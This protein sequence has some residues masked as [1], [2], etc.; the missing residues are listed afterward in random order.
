[1]LIWALLWGDFADGIKVMEFRWQVLT[2]QIHVTPKSREV[3]P[4]EGKWKDREMRQ[5][6]KTEI[7]SPSGRKKVICQGIQQTLEAENDLQPMASKDTETSV[8]W[9]QGTKSSQP[10][11]WARKQTVHRTAGKVPASWQLEFSLLKLGVDKLAEPT[12][13]PDQLKCEIINELPSAAKS[14]IIGSC[15]TASW[16]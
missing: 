4:A 9:L 5:K 2:E 1:M 7:R 6:G 8:L 13:T 11:E 15:H 16:H 14:V 10:P 12:P 3:H